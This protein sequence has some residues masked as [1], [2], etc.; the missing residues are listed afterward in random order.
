MAASVEGPPDPLETVRK[1][2]ARREQLAAEQ[3]PDGAASARR[4]T[5]TVKRISAAVSDRSTRVRA[6]ATND[7]N[8]PVFHLVFVAVGAVA[9]TVATVWFMSSWSVDADATGAPTLVVPEPTAIVTPTP[10]PTPSPTPTPAP[11]AT[12]TP[13]P[14]ILVHVSGRVA[15]PGVVEV[16]L[17]ARSHV[18]L[19]AVGGAL[20]DADLDRVNLA[21]P[22][23]DGRQLHVPAVGE[24]EATEADVERYEPHVPGPTPTPAPPTQL[25]PDAPAADLTDG[26]PPPIPLESDGS[27]QAPLDGS[28]PPWYDDEEPPWGDDE[29]E[30]PTPVP[31][32]AD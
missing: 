4:G 28:L 12:P 14:T 25:A 11:T 23:A 26:S 24:D 32:A 20:D 31:S 21:A 19:E 10:E 5:R 7:A 16:P 8:R 6:A 13:V 30:W 2:R 27:D 29:P 18:A 9:M 15:N 22:L 3:A 1:R 17:G